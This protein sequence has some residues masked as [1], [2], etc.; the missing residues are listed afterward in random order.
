MH[1]FANVDALE[2]SELTD[3]AKSKEIYRHIIPELIE[4]NKCTSIPESKLI[5]SID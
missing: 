2:P 4:A 1:G 5:S 3:L